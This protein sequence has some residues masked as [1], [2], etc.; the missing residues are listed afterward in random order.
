MELI[1]TVGV[2][3]V[4]LLF[5]RFVWRRFVATPLARTNRVFAYVAATLF[6]LLIG[7]AFDR[8]NLVLSLAMGVIVAAEVLDT[9]ASRS[10]AGPT[11]CS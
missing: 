8:W 4:A 2:A 1:I 5:T 10:D 11:T 3:L 6:G 7:M 9:V